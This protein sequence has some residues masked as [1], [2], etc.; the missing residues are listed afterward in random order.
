M[1]VK[2]DQ[3]G[4]LP[5]GRG[6]SRRRAMLEAA[7]DLFLERGFAE[8]SVGDVVKR[9]GGSLATLYAVFGSKEGL[10]EAIVGEMS[11]QMLSGLDAS[12]VNSRPLDEAL[13]GFGESF[14]GAALS[15]NSL[16]WQR[17]CIAEAHN[18]PELRAALIRTGPGY[19]SGR[20]ASYLAA[21]VEAGRLRTVDPEIAAMHFFALVKSESHLA[22]V[23]GE[24]IRADKARIR[25]QV[26]RAV[27]V[28]LRGYSAEPK[29]G[30]QPSKSSRPSSRRGRSSK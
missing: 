5:S 18:F 3:S 4:A 12:E 8:T 29:S 13:R 6:E 16:R 27:E 15:P 22:A 23:C 20:M 24:P 10:F 28:F 9:S 14:L 2:K 17:M 26:R 1:S 21:Q 11:A 7:G 30:K 19:V 25:L